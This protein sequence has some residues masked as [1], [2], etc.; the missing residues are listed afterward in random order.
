MVVDKPPGV[1]VHGDE[2]SLSHRLRVLR[3]DQ[4]LFPVHRLDRD[5]SGLLLIAKGVQSN[6]ILSPLFQQRKVEKYY[7]A[8]VNKKPRKKQGTII[9]DIVPARGGSWKLS[10][11]RKNPSVTQ[12]FSFGLKD[13]LRAVLIKPYTGKTHQIRVVMKS[14]G[15]PIVGDKRYGGSDSDRMYLHADS[16]SFDAFESSFKIQ[17]SPSPGELF[18]LSEFV[19]LISRVN[20]ETLAWPRLTS[21]Y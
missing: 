19:S 4:T 16:L 15:A 21:F 1:S 13:G 14:L 5:T 10:Q 20:K 3:C 12:F 18:S 2:N 7:W 6:K 11:E 8:I 17:S 9:G